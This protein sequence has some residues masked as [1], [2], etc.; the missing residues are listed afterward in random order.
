MRTRTAQAE[1][2]YNGK[3][4]ATSLERHFTSLTYTDPATGEGDTLSITLADPD[5][6]WSNA[7]LPR[8][9]D[10]LQAVIA[11]RDWLREGDGRQLDCGT[12]TLDDLSFSGWGGVVELGAI[13]A[14]VNSN[15]AARERTKTWEN[16]TLKKIANDIAYASGLALVY[17]APEIRLDAEEQ[18]GKTD[19]AFLQGLCNDYGVCLKVFSQKLVLFDRTAYKQKDAAATIRAEELLSYTYRTT[20]AGSYTGGTITYTNPKTEEDVTYSVGSGARI[21]KCSAKADSKADAELKLK[22]ALEKANHNLTSLRVTTLGNPALVASQTVNIV[23]LGQLS[24]KYYIEKAT[25]TLGASGYT[26]TYEL[27]LVDAGGD[28][29]VRDAIARL[30]GIGVINTPNYWLAHYQDV[31]HLEELLLNLSA[32]IRVRRRG[33]EIQEVNAALDVLTAHGVMN[34]PDYWAANYGALA[35]LDDLLVQAANALEGD[36]L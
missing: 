14:P 31:K 30:V 22:A 3:A 4:I 13:S 21:L 32:R 35:Y 33:T 24:G 15:F 20:L 7:W 11:V 9:G 25:H 26:T 5:A 2:L 10:Q 19:S 17:D 18:K 12:F 34:S 29:A 27:P 36:M 8:K 23:G 6:V 16:I 28:A 1:I